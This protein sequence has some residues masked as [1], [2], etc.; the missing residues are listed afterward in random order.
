MTR[1]MRRSR[2]VA[3]PF[4]AATMVLA[5]SGCLPNDSFRIVAAENLLRTFSLVTQG[6]TAVVFGLGDSILN[7][8]AN[9]LLS[10]LLPP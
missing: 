8:I 4:V 9:S 6:S 2:V 7:A 1:V 10:S 5:V 3:L